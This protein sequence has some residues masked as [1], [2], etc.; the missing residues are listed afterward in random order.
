VIDSRM[1]RGRQQIHHS[2]SGPWEITQRIFELKRLVHDYCVCDG[3]IAGQSDNIMKSISLTSQIHN[4][5]PTIMSSLAISN[6]LNGYEM[7]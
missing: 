4:K 2:C 5:M 3:R 1:K 7:N 6:G